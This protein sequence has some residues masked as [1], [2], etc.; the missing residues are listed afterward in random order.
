MLNRK[1]CK[2]CGGQKDNLKLFVTYN[3]F[4]EVDKIDFKSTRLFVRLDNF[5]NISL[6]LVVLYLKWWFMLILLTN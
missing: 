6:I 1:K 3:S 5:Q 4:V 2:P